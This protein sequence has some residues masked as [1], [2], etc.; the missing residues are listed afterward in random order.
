[1]S[2]ITATEAQ[3]AHYLTQWQTLDKYVMQE[4]C[5]NLL[6]QDLCINNTDLVKVLLKVS[7]LNDFYS[8]NIYDTHSVAR[9]IHSLDIDEKISKGDLN[10]IDQMANVNFNG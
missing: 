3:V 5:V 2:E 7:S 4:S 1:M 10:L 6:F 9:H 8:T